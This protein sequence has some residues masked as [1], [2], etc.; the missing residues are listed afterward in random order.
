MTEIE[1]NLNDDNDDDKS[2]EDE[3][4]ENS[5]EFNIQEDLV[6]LHGS[7]LKMS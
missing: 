1:N 5:D 3:E 2:F 4:A 6:K 7:L